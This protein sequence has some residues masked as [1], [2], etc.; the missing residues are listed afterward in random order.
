MKNSSAQGRNQKNMR[1]FHR[2]I[3]A[4]YS[5]EDADIALQLMVVLQKKLEQLNF[6]DL[7]EKVEFPLI[8]VLASM[9]RVGVKV[10]TEILGQ[11]SKELNG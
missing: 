8:E 10:D 9:E 7:C 11:I 4:E 5:G 3:V 1:K 6:S 2:R